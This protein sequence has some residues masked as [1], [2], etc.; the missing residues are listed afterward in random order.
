MLLLI[1]LF[2]LLYNILFY[3]YT[4]IYLYNLQP[5]VWVISQWLSIA[6]ILL[7][8]FLNI[9]W[10]IHTKVCLGNIAKIIISQSKDMCNFNIIIYVKLFSKLLVPI[11]TPTSIR[12]KILIFDVFET[13]NFCHMN[14]YYQTDFYLLRKRESKILHDHIGLVLRG[15]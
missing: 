15:E 11:Y 7:E 3:N 10:Y 4:S 8:T 14:V 5:I 1:N 12:Q 9:P 13:S 6:K 2:S